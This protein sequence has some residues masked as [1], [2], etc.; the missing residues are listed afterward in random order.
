M[1]EAQKRIDDSAA[2]T[3]R[4][5]VLA[6]VLLT[7]LYSL[8]WIGGVSQHFRGEVSINQ[9]WLSALFLTL[10][11]MIVLVSTPEW[12]E[13]FLLLAV[14]LLGFIAEVVGVHLAFPFGAYAYTDSLG[15]RLFAVP[16]VMT[17]AWL[18]LA[19]Y[20]K[21]MLKKLKLWR[22][23]EPVVG[24]LWM[25]AF[26]LLIDPLAANQLNYWRWIGPGDY[27]GVPLSNFAGW[28]GVSILVFLILQK[29]FSENST[30]RLVGLSIV[31]FF[32]F[33]AAAHGSVGV[34]LVGGGLCVLHAVIFNL[35]GRRG[36]LPF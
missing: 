21:Q 19:A 30:A 22:W 2:V 14:A 4:S 34:A 10:A 9:G 31:L 12:R 26:D 18:T 28:F 35:H 16:L 15:P 25:T 5:R 24:A 32:T 11:G 36:L 13:R 33:I 8:M 20:V 29:R 6:L 3:G 23:L 7:A 17:F 27:Y 1:S